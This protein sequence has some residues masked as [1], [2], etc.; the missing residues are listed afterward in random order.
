[1]LATER[2]L[3]IRE[4]FAPIVQRLVVIELD[5]EM[6][7][8]IFYL[9]DGTNLRVSEQWEGVTLKRYSYYW[10]TSKNDL[11]IGWDNA[12]HHTRLESF[13]HH[14]HV[15]ERGDLHPSFETCL[16]DVMTVISASPPLVGGDD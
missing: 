11:K 5:D 10:L 15:G 12:P 6:L 16:E 1:M 9:Q 8:L 4:R 2:L 7:Q 13:P 3:E 14:K